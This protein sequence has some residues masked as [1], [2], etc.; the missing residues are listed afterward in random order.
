MKDTI[1]LILSI[2]HFNIHIYS[3]EYKESLLA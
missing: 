1:N 3:N 2:Y